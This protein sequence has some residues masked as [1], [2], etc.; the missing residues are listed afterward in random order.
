MPWAGRAPSKPQ[1]C[2]RP[3]N[4]SSGARSGTPTTQRPARLNDAGI[5]HPRTE[6][7]VRRCGAV[8]GWAAIACFL[9]GIWTKLGAFGTGT[10]M[11]LTGLW[12]GLRL[13]TGILQDAR[14][15]KG[16]TLVESWR[17]DPERRQSGLPTAYAEFVRIPLGSWWMRLLT[18]A[19]VLGLLFLMGGAAN[20][21]S[22][23]AS[24]ERRFFIGLAVAA[25]ALL[26][27]SIML[28]LVVGRRSASAHDLLSELQGSESGRTSPVI[29]R[30]SPAVSQ[31]AD[32]REAT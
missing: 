7:I 19:T 5:L 26:L 18:P 24:D 14:I 12:C 21:G 3:K 10:V 31:V 4:A 17:S 27:S 8:A 16:S 15:R 30:L 1:H 20:I 29:H 32:Q 22:A 2:S 25:A 28:R 9:L 13:I 11:A 23:T 6:Q